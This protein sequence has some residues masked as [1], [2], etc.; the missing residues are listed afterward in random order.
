MA[1]ETTASYPVNIQGT[2]QVP[3]SRWLFLLKWL[4]LIPHFIVLALLFVAFAVSVLIT[5]FAVLFTGKYP[6]GLF[7]FNV[8]VLRWSWRVSFYSYSA[9]GTDKYP[10]FSLA[11]GGYPADLSVEYP[12]QLNR[13][14]VLVKWLLAIPHFL[15]VGFFQ[16]GG[17]IRY[18]DGGLVSLLV[19][20]AAVINLSTGKYP[21]EIFE[22]LMG[23]NRWSLR[24]MA[25]AALMTDA[26][27][28]FRLRE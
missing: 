12:Q 8:G 20:V 2:L 23:L 19:L 10:P 25:Y 27:P 13:W 11:A 4:L 1:Q 15:I 7:D 14:L 28:P 18:F 21:K 5:L 6:C 16:G 26:Y 22:L 17:G 9:L 24:V 3:L